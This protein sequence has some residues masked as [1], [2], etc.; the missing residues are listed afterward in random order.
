MSPPQSIRLSRDWLTPDNSTT[1][2]E[3]A[4]PAPGPRLRAG[5]GGR[6]IDSAFV[7]DGSV[8]GCNGVK[9]DKDS[10]IG[11]LWY[12]VQVCDGKLMQEGL[13]EDPSRDFIFP[14][15]AVDAFGNVGIGC[16]G[17]SE[18]ENPS[19]YVMMHRSIDP[20]G[21]MK[22][23]VLAVPGT[24]PYLYAGEAAVNLSHYSSTVLDP[25]DPSLLW[26]YQ[27]CSKSHRDRQ[28]TTA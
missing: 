13:V 25:V 5:G 21:T 6:R 12:E 4:Q 3:A 22:P 10:R 19:V 2:M 24:T 18:N 8:F 7:R 1:L 27:A 15:I 28:W 14:A 23:P 20:P 17:T 26:T 9:S 11:V 16:T